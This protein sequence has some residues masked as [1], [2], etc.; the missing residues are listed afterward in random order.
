MKNIL[1]ISILTFQVSKF[2]LA[3]DATGGGNGGDH[4]STYKVNA[5]KTI[6]ANM[7][8]IYNFFDLLGF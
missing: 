5:L 2:N 3:K 1:L 6:K 7:S 8:E 4:I